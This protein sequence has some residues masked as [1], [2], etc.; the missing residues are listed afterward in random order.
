M[1]PDAKSPAPYEFG[2]A[3]SHM[4]GDLAGKMQ[5]VGLFTILFAIVVLGS[6]LGALAYRRGE[7]ITD[8]GI[9]VAAVQGLFFLALGFWTRRAGSQFRMVDETRGHDVEHLMLALRNLH[10]LYAV[11]YWLCLLAIT[12]VVVVIVFSVMAS[13]AL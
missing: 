9:L 12:F 8:P 10:K 7:G 5:F 6:G 13:K 4:I 1:P 11:Q 2:P 3:D